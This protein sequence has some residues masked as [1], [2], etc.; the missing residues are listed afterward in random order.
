MVAAAILPALTFAVICGSA[1]RR[2]GRPEQCF[3]RAEWK[4]AKRYNGAAR[5]SWRS[6]PIPAEPGTAGPIPAEPIPAKPGRPWCA[7]ASR[8]PAAFTAA[9]LQRC[10]SSVWRRSYCWFRQF[11]QRQNY[12]GL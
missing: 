8:A 12:S 2:A 1:G 4:R 6:R 3:R 11:E 5:C 10:S 9:W 7:D